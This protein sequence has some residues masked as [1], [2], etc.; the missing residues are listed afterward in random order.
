MNILHNH[1]RCALPRRQHGVALIVALI[2]LAGVTLISMA[3]VGQSAME[4]RMARNLDTAGNAFQTAESVVDVI[5]QNADTTLP[6]SGPLLVP[7]DVTATLPGTT[8]A[9]TVFYSSGGETITAVAVRML[10]CAPPPR[11]RTG[12]SITA[13]SAFAYEIIADVNRNE[14]GNGRAG[15]SQG[16]VTL[17][18][19]C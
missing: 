8:T 12:S 16:Y 7:T 14:T 19:K 3:G 2:I 11:A 10:D 6:T 17:G 18:P 13:F 15:I 5:L 9:N 1:S 4:L